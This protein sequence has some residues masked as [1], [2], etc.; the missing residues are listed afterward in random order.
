[1]CYGVLYVVLD[2]YYIKYKVFEVFD[3]FEGLDLIGKLCCDLDLCYLYD[4]IEWGVG[5][6]NRCYDGKVC[7]D[8]FI[9]GWWCW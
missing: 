1:M 7:F 3:E 6:I 8:D 5:L 4:E 9:N 2:G